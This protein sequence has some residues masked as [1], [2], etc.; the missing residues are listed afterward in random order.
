MTISIAK[1][2]RAPKDDSRK[3]GRS[4]LRV[5]VQ[6]IASLSSNMR[7]RI[8]LA[9]LFSSRETMYGRRIFST[10]KPHSNVRTVARVE[11]KAADIK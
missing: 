4:F 6:K 8:P 9:V 1:V 10:R 5:V 2:L 11:W 7:P 3:P